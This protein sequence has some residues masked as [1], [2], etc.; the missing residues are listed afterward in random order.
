MSMIIGKRQ[1]I[2]AAL[3]VALGTAIF[4][5]WKF[6]GTNGGANVAGVFNAS[7]ALGTSTYVS[8]SGAGSTA[9]GA[10]STASSAG[11]VASASGSLFAQQRLTRTKTRAEAEQALQITLN[12]TTATAADKQA[13]QTQISGIANNI[14]NEGYVESLIVSKG[15]KDCVCFINNGTVSV[16]VAPKGN[17]PLSTSDSAQIADIV[18]QQTKVSADNIHIIQSK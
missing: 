11:S 14:T 2:L 10:G 17:Q 5:N 8:T 13:A 4:L 12:S 1:I 6:T 3:V 7:S 15:F 16:V 18:M 9:S